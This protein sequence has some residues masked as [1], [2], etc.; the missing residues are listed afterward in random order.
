MKKESII[1]ILIFV[2]FLIGLFIRLESI[3]IGLDHPGNLKAGNAFYHT[4]IPTYIAEGSHI[5]TYPANMAEGHDNI[6]NIV[7]QHQALVIAPL[8]K[9][10]SIEDWNLSVLIVAIISALSIPIMFIL[11]KSIFKS[12]SVAILSAALM[13]FY[14]HRNMAPIISNDFYFSIFLTGLFDI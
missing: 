10:T 1:S 11:A 6:I 3:G 8:I 13:A 5:F 4:I 9:L 12:D 7:S 14:I 2:L